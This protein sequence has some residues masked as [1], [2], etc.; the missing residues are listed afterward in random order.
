MIRRVFPAR[1][2]K[3]SPREVLSNQEMASKEDNFKDEWEE[4]EEEI[5][6]SICKDLFT[7]PKTILCLHTFC[8]KCMKSTIETNRRLG[9]EVCCPLCRTELSQDL[10]KVPTNFAIKRLIEIFRKRE[11]SILTSAQIK[12][13]CGECEEDGVAVIWCTDCETFQC[14]ECFKQHQRMKGLKLHKTVSLEDFMQSPRQMV[15]LAKPDNCK[16]HGM[17]SL[18]L[19]CQTCKILICRDCTF[20]D[21][22]QHQYNFVNKLADEEHAKIKMVAAPL[23]MMLEQVDT[24]IKK[25]EDVDNEL[26]NETDAEKQVQDMYRQLRQMLDQSEV[27]DLQKIKVAKIML[28]DLLSSQKGNLKLLQACLVSCDEFVSKVTTRERASQLLTYSNDIQERVNYLTNQVQQSPLEPVCGVD[29]MILSTCNPNDYVSHFTSL[30]TI[31]TLPHVP[32]CSV[33]GPPGMSKYGPVNVIVTLKDED[34]RPVPNQTEH[35]SVRFED[36]NIARS[37]KIEERRC[38]NDYVL[39]YWLHRK[40]THTLSVSWKKNVLAEI[41][42]PA[43]VRNYEA[44]HEGVQIIDKYGP[45]E[46]RL[47][48]PYLLTVGPNNE[49]IFRDYHV[50]QLVIF[51]DQLRHV[52]SI[53]QGSVDHPTAVAV[54]KNGCLYVSDYYTSVVKKISSTGEVIFEFGTGK[55]KLNWPL[56]LLLLQSKLLFICDCNNNR[57][58]VLKDDQFSYSFGQYGKNPGYFYHPIDLASNPTEDQLFITDSANNRIQVFSPCGQFL[59]VFGNSTKVQYELVL[60]TG[61]CYTPDG[62]ILVSS[63]GVHSVLVFDEDGQFVSA[64]E[65]YYQGK[66]RLLQPIGVVMMN[67]GKIVVAGD[68]SN[69]LV[70]F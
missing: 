35:L 53:G 28:Q 20:V 8:E 34:G 45:D 54:S 15:A 5:T 44:I 46:E 3:R 50:K 22:R 64:I 36:E 48:H 41:E 13:K 56:G 14:E 24:A 6:C 70:V 60:P 30:C 61:I 58:V 29:H 31:S 1:I 9:S 59:R 16:D 42:I 51:D 23:K 55:D 49:L 39:C 57:I 40:E 47:K 65:G 67:N 2:Y 52:R 19:Y 17:Q 68:S 62:H 25:V 21:H 69:N 63:S 18:D 10:A 32:N 66:H 43:N 7:E 33:K 27:K 4:I 11:K 26:K 38:Q 12:V 37:V